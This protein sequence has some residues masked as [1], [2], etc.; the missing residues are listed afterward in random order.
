MQKIKEKKFK[1]N[2]Y[3]HKDETVHPL[4]RTACYKSDKNKQRSYIYILRI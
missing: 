3:L 2:L 4:K 1:D